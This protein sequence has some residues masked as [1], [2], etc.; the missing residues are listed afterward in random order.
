MSEKRTPIIKVHLLPMLI[1]MVGHK[2]IAGFEDIIEYMDI[3]D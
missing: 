3:E 1:G 2:P